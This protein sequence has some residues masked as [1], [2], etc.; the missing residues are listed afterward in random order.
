MIDDIQKKIDQLAQKAEE[1]RADPR[2][3]LYS[4]AD[5]LFLRID[6]I[7]ATNREEFIADLDESSLMRINTQINNALDLISSIKLEKIA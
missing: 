3:K 1:L 4:E 7:V 2:T 6:A 5:K